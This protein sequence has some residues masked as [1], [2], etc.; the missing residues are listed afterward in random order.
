MVAGSDYVN[1]KHSR[2]ETT[3]ELAGDSKNDVPCT[4][5]HTECTT[6]KGVRAAVE[7]FANSKNIQVETTSG[8]KAPTWYLIKP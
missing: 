2:D 1:P 7:E 8:D 3:K 6:N 5:L 4:G